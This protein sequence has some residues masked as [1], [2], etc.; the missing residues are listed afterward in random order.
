MA[1]A[2]Q[3]SR[4]HQKHNRPSSRWPRA[5][6]QEPGTQKPSLL[7]LITPVT[8]QEG[9]QTAGRSSLTALHRSTGAGQEEAP[10]VQLSP[11][12]S[13]A[14]GFRE[15]RCASPTWTGDPPHIP[16]ADILSHRGRQSALT[17]APLPEVLPFRKWLFRSSVELP[18]HLTS[19]LLQ[20]QPLLSVS[21]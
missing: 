20:L 9:L 1:V 12:A 7:P 6:L 8:G 11:G 17:S 4:S 15:L 3:R 16:S 2:R 19:R 14:L 21:K 18:S 10:C 5:P 13:T